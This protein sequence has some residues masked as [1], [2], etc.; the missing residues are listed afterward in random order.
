MS[1]TEQQLP[2]IEDMGPRFFEFIEGLRRPVVFF[3]IE[4]T[5]TDTHRDRII[6][7]CL[8][9]V[10]PLPVAVAPR[11]AW[12]EN[13]AVAGA[14]QKKETQH[15]KNAPKRPRPPGRGCAPPPARKKGAG[16]GGGV[17]SA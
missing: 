8:L 14:L 10:C 15:E 4:S 13:P 11:K 17:W 1:E 6:E 16:G 5:G 7:I 12:R 3:D 9:R 2:S